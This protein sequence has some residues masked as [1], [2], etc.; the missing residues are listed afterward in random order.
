MLRRFAPFLVAL[1]VAACSSSEEETP[2]VR[3]TIT[4]LDAVPDGS[5]AFVLYSLRETRTVPSDSVTT[6]AWDIGFR[7]TEVI[8]NGGTSGVGAGVGVLVDLPFESVGEAVVEAFFF[9]RDGESP[10][11]SGPARAVCDVPGDD[12]A[13]YSTA[14]LAGGGTAIVPVDGR[15]LVLRLA[16]GQGYAKIDFESYYRGAPDPPRATSEP[17]FYTFEVVA[18]PEGSS[19]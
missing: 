11:P 8:L 18:N 7:G 17:G 15:T 16:D 1:S 2:L 5:G 13:W 9:R 3:E 14:P 10:C 19:F 4:D 12:D 6:L